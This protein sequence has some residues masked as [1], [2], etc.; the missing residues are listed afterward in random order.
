MTYRV[1]LHATALAQLAGLPAEAFDA[2]VTC[3]AKMSAEPWDALALP[4]FDP[5]HRQAVFGTAGLVSFHVSDA[6][7]TITVYDI[8]WAG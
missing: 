1:D 3:V 8:T 4:A 5:E 2:L 6:T 7:A